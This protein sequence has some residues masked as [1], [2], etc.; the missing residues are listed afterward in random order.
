MNFKK[1]IKIEIKIKKRRRSAPFSSG[2]HGSDPLL[3]YGCD[4]PVDYK[5][6]RTRNYRIRGEQRMDW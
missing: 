2:A 6:P 1:K 3:P 4:G 5:L